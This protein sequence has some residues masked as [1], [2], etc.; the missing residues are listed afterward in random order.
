M[1]V[2]L[3]VCLLICLLVAWLV[4]CL[5]AK[6]VGCLVDHFL[7]GW[8]VDPKSYHNI[9]ERIQWVSPQPGGID[10]IDRFLS[11]KVTLQ[12]FRR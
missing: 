8:L 4:G 9:V 2:C 5:V 3:F 12:I 11:N 6:L 10:H 7:V 1:F